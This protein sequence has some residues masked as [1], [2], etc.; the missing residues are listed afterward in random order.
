MVHERG[1]PAPKIG[2]LLSLHASDSLVML[3]TIRG[4]P[5]DFDRFFASLERIH[6]KRTHGKGKPS[7]SPEFSLFVAP[8]G[9]LPTTR[10]NRMK[11]YLVACDPFP[12]NVSTSR[13]IW[14]AL[15]S[16]R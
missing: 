11:T 15:R 16:Q 14:S 7:T 5:K 6:L 8:R 3:G 9:F 2:I 4:R 12:R 13:T 1:S 10:N